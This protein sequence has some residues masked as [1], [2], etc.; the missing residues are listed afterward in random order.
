[1]KDP[2]SDTPEPSHAMP[3]AARCVA[4]AN[5][6]NFD[7]ARDV[8]VDGLAEKGAYKQRR[9]VES[10]GGPLSLRSGRSALQ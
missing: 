3:V 7:R 8:F 9:L 4:N 10:S 5:T 2:V 1:M 6:P